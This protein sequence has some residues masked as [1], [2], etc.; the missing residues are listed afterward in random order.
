M[1][2]GPGR[3]GGVCPELPLAAQYR[4]R[5]FGIHDQ[6]NKIRSLPAQLQTD[7]CTFER[8]QCGS[9]PMSSKVPAGSAGDRSSAE[10]A[11]DADCELQNRGNHND[12]FGLVEQIL[13]N[14]VG[15]VH[16]FLEHL[17]TCCKALLFPAFTR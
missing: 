7:V 4:V 2:V 3:G 13:R 6:Q 16:N 15:D 8:E 17:A 14:A 10:V 12:A 9:A 5:P 11:S 1:P